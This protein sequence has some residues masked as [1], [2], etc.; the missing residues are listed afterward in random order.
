MLH[1]NEILKSRR[2]FDEPIYSQVLELYVPIINNDGDLAYISTTQYLNKKKLIPPP[3]SE[4]YMYSGNI[5][6]SCTFESKDDIAKINELLYVPHKIYKFGEI[7]SK[8]YTVFLNEN[9]KAVDSFNIQN[10]PINIAISWEPIDY[11]YENRTRIITSDKQKAQDKLDVF[12][13][14]L[15]REFTDKIMKLR[16]IQ[17]K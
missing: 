3:T 1:I 13:V 5:V 11:S 9:F 16:S 6:D 4:F 17:L 7:Y 2:T 12:K 8:H 14:D 10:D 15:A